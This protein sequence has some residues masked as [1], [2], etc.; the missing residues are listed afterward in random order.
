M[1]FS[2]G[3][4]IATIALALLV[5]P[6]PS[7]AQPTVKVY[8]IGYLVNS[9]ASVEV[10]R[11]S[12]FIKGLRDLGWIEGQNVVVESRYAEGNPIFFA[13][14]VMLA[15]YTLLLPTRLSLLLL[16][17]AFIGIRQQV[18]TEEA[19]LSRTYGEAYR[20]YARHVGRFVPGRGKL[21]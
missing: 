15:G 5:A 16:V 19:Y 4:R 14:L 18:L 3:L 2:T 13:I 17:G 12:A 8:R 11:K 9:S 6:L 1:I 7:D 20:A 10:H 21:G